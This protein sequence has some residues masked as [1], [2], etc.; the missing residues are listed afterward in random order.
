MSTTDQAKKS[1]YDYCKTMLG[2][3]M[4]DVELDP[5][6][7]ETAL[8]R[9]LAVFRQRSDNAVEESY[10]FLTMQE[11][12]NEYI[13]PKEITDILELFERME[14]EQIDEVLSYARQIAVN[15]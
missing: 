7:Y 14:L 5:I 4:V 15:I 13:L 3:G 1:V 8:N 9:A 6:H 10:A 11:N 12:I 2:D